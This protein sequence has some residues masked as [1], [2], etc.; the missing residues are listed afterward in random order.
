MRLAYIISAYQ[1]P[2]QLIR[3]VHRIHTPRSIIII[4]VDKR[5][6]RRKYLEMVT[7]V[8]HL[9][10]IVF[11]ERHNCHWGSF[12]HVRATLK[13]LSYLRQHKRYD[14]VFLITGQDYPIKSNREV[15]HFLSEANNVNFVQYFPLPFE[16]WKPENSGFDRAE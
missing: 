4:H 15:E 16:R 8:E 10:N 2:A 11:L 14:Y 6:D 1:Y 5:T 7:G 13:G 3:L 9:P 12:G